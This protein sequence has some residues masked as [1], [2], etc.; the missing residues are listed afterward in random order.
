MSDYQNLDLRSLEKR[1]AEGTSL[2]GVLVTLAVVV[3]LFVLLAA[4][5]AGTRSGDRALPAGGAEDSAPPVT[6]PAGL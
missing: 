3:V 1:R 4:L 5:G 6:Q 2:R